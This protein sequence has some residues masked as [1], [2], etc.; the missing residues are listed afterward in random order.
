MCVGSTFDTKSLL[1]NPEQPRARWFD[2]HDDDGDLQQQQGPWTDMQ[3][4]E[5]FIVPDWV[6]QVWDGTVDGLSE[7]E[8]D[9]AGELEDLESDL[10]AELENLELD[11][12]AEP[13]NLDL[14]LTA[15]LENLELELSDEQVDTMA[16]DAET[17]PYPPHEAA[18]DMDTDMES[19]LALGSVKGP[20]DAKLELFKGTFENSKVDPPR[21]SATFEKVH[22]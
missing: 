9:G 4:D 21:T 2:M 3:N 22:L 19:S 6:Q 13:E 1:V 15:E 7:Y 16:S 14:D 17:L 11:L 18:S 10:S 8:G 12:S 5:N 20:P